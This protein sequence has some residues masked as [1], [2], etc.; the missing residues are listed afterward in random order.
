MCNKHKIQV[1]IALALACAS[2]LPAW[3]TEQT[4]KVVQD[5]SESSN[6]KAPFGGPNEAEVFM[7]DIKNRNE[8]Q[9]PSYVFGTFDRAMKPWFDFKQKLEEEHNYRIGGH[10]QLVYQKANK[11]K[12][13]AEADYGF[14]GLLRVTNTW[15]PSGRN[16]PNAG[17]LSFTIDHRHKLGNG[18]A[19]ASLGGQVGYRGNT[20]AIMTDSDFDLVDLYWTQPLCNDTCGFVVGRM[21][22]N[23]Y[24]YTHSFS[25]PWAG[26]MNNEA[27]N[28]TA[29]VQPQ[30]AWGAVAATHITDQV[31]IVGG[32]ADSNGK[33]QDDLQWFSGGAE[34][35]KAI[36]VG[37]M[38]D[39]K[40]KYDK[41]ITFTL[42]HQD[43]RQDIPW[44]EESYGMQSTV[45]WLFGD[46]NPYMRVGIS[47][48]TAPTYNKNILVGFRKKMRGGADWMGLSHSYGESSR[49]GE[50]GADSEDTQITTAFF[51]SYYLAKNLA[52]T[53]DLQY[54]QCPLDNPKEKS[55]VLAALRLRMTF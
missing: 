48:G 44:A 46:Y 20:S 27:V 42:W 35:W 36:E 32:L 12:Q 2:I 53:G 11:T 10:Y 17:R 34:L 7:N 33:A 9:G 54:I 31:Y 37:Y 6:R 41:K 13:D 51:Y 45:S 23:S 18:V 19:P 8:D 30:S 39:E 25:T 26:H 21:D 43:E 50:P 40:H 24:F 49:K 15:T 22:I 28:T 16:T 14:G 52:L 55:V 1:G 5:I 47:E 38:H 4:P 3:S 29:L